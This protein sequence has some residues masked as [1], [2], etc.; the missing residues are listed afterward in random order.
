M[1]ARKAKSNH[2][3]IGIF[4]ILLLVFG[5][6]S[7]A[8]QYS[9]PVNNNK[10][11]AQ[12]DLGPFVPIGPPFRSTALDTVSNG[13]TTFVSYQGQG[14]NNVYLALVLS[15]PGGT[16]EK[17]RA[18]PENR[19]PGGSDPAIAVGG[20]KIVVTATR[21]GDIAITEC[22]DNEDNCKAPKSVS[23][24]NDP[25]VSDAGPDQTVNEGD[26]VTLDGTGSSDPNGDIPL[27][28]AWSQ[29]AGPSVMLSN[30]SAAQPT[31]T[32]PDVD[33]DDSEVDAVDTDDS[34][35]LTFSLTVT[36]SK[37]LAD[38]TPDSVTITVNDV[39]EPTEEDTLAL[40]TDGEDN[41]GDELVDSD[42]PDCVSFVE[43]EE[44]NRGS[45][46]DRVDNDADGLIDKDDPGCEGEICDDDIDND[47]DEVVD[48]DDSDCRVVATAPQGDGNN[49]TDVEP[50]SLN[51]QTITSPQLIFVQDGGGGG[52]TS[53]PSNSD[54]AASSD[55]DD[56]YIVWEQD[57]DIKFTAGH[58]CADANG[59]ELGAILD[60]SNSNAG[61]ST[62]A[63][64]ATSSDGQF[65][66]VTWQDNTP[67]NDDIFY[68]RSED[69][70]N[71][72][73][74][75]LVGNPTNLSNTPQASNDHQ[76]VAEGTNVYVVWVD[77]T[78][79]NGDIFFRKS[80][81]NGASGSFSN[82]NNLSTNNRSFSTA[83][84][85]D[86]AAQGSLVSV[87]W[88]AYHGA[89]T[90]IGEIIFRES[91]S[92]GNSFGSH[93][94]VSNTPGRDSKEP[95]VDYTPEENERYFAWHD[96]GGPRRVHTPAGTYN[97]LAAE[98]DNGS[99]I[100]PSVNLSDAPNNPDKSKQTSQLQLVDDVAIWDPTSRR[101]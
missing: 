59:C 91:T 46:S 79:G 14:E 54:V 87:V 38:P 52:D 82:T 55:G 65:V 47:L 40:C 88:T 26:T 2:S 94:L 43:N 90:R 71:T 35:V 101:G 41:D 96:T 37:G 83:R 92:N 7:L 25:P 28:Y 50:T 5:V 17:L 93:I 70:G 12:V 1:G 57:G 13:E 81:E 39:A 63:R 42:D 97:V 16:G 11:Y 9:A 95:Q 18:P 30:P 58:G 80:N 20:N 4:G 72:F 24:P 33:T 15:G 3:I 75:N 64:V 36:D 34:E 10:A 77:F 32:A 44:V 89:A 23:S 68:L 73:G 21:D 84:D 29:T 27:T 61:R 98:S 53:T 66:H 60:L 6:L 69:A 86:M 48:D 76:L 45:C 51:P 78:T 99:T 31:F 22:T 62:E 56:V 49:T 19:V 85:P 8:F 100:S 74:G 67:G